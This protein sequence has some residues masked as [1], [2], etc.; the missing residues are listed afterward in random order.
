[1]TEPSTPATLAK[2]ADFA[3][4]RHPETVCSRCVMSTSDPEI[5]FDQAGRCNHCTAF[6]SRAPGLTYHGVA[7]ELELKRI[8]ETVKRRGA[9]RRYDCVIG[10]SGGV[11]SCYA[12]VIAKQLGLR[13]LAVHVDNGWNSDIAVKNIKKLATAL[14]MDYTSVVLDWP[15]FR[16]LQL[17]FLKASVVEVETPTDMAIPAA[18]H[19]VAA[20]HGVRF[21]VAGG[22]FATEGIL[23][24]SWHY[25]AKDVRYLKSIHARFGNLRR[26]RRFPTFGFWKELYYKFARGIRTIYLLNYAPYS[27]DEAMRLLQ[28]QFGWTYY[29]GKHH[30]SHITGFVQ[31]YVLPLKFGIDYRRATLS[32]Q[33]CMGEVTRSAALEE[34]KRPPFDDAVVARQKEYVAKKFEIT[35]DELDRL[36]AAPPKRHYDY[37]NNERWLEALYGL[38]RRFTY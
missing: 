6:V 4:G 5:T 11:D 38:Y 35:T 17:A 21:I 1:M 24:A 14:S 25:N 34:L 32:C 19:S 20:R 16:D 3:P 9:K 15:E 37:P 12:M 22:N 36:I 29:G 31:S 26:L 27:K 28:E 10:V 8:V 30:E 23:P 13:C 18:L 33:V 7:T 2:R